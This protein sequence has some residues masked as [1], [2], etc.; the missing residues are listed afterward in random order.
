MYKIGES[1]QC[2]NT[3][4]TLTSLLANQEQ[5]IMANSKPSTRTFSEQHRRAMSVAAKARCDQEWRKRNSDRHRTKLD[6]GRLKLLYGSGL[7][8]SECASALGVSQKVVWRALKRL[9]VKAR[10]SVKRNQYG[11]NNSSWKGGEAT[12]SAFHARVIAVRG[13]P[14]LCEFCGAT[15]GR[16]EWSNQTGAYQN[17]EDYKRLCVSCHKRFDAARRRKDGTRLSCHIPRKQKGG[18]S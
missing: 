16:F 13:K 4:P 14:S 2:A 1:A 17:V 15:S 9:G 5:S 3:I 11:A 10:K 8:Q 18:M 6:D 12:Y 7:T